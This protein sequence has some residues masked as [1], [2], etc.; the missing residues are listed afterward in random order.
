MVAVIKLLRPANCVMGLV[1]VL[2]GALV[3]KGL[4][5]FG[6]KYLFELMLGMFI[7]FFFMSAGNML[8]D[9]FDREQ[10][11]INHP[12]RPIPSGAIKPNQVIV[13]AG[14]IFIVL[15]ILGILVNLTMFMILILATFLMLGYE[16]VFKRRGLVGNFT[17]GLLVGMLFLFGAAVVSEF[18]VVVFLF[19]L[20]LLATLTREIVKDIE[21][22][23]GDIDRITLP[24]QIGIKSSASIAAVVIIIAIILSPFPAL[25]QYFPL[26]SYDG[27]G[28]SY[29]VL[30]IPADL[31]FIF[32]I[33][34]Y[35]KNPK[36]AQNL[37][38]LGMLVGLIAYA[39]GSII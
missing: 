3:G 29:L 9:Y 19:I 28:L 5:I 11:L 32:S 33:K 1:G 13:S 31:I 14:A 17:I 20:A 35:A 10:D 6:S 8:N 26:F 22:I 23:K 25:P 21:D 27:L 36:L 37:L 18:G 15:L 38:K 4:D 12:D 16:L 2:I 24:K 34:H 30:I 39:V 7:A